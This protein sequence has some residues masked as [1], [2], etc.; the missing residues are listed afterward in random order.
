MVIWKTRSR[1]FAFMVS[2]LS[3]CAKT[4]FETEKDG[5]QGSGEEFF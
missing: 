3:V 5:F 4:S 2:V 1:F